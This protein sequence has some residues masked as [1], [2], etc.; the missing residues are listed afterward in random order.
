MTGGFPLVVAM[1]KEKCE[2]EEAG[3]GKE[4]L[5]SPVSRRLLA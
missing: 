4:D 1:G 2:E 5:V 3:L